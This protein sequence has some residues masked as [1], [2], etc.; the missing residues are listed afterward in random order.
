MFFG[1]TPKLVGYPADW[2]PAKKARNHLKDLT[3]GNIFK[4]YVN[5]L[6]TISLWGSWGREK[7]R[8]LQMGMAVFLLLL[9]TSFLVQIIIFPNINGWSDA[10]PTYHPDPA[11]L[12]ICSIITLCSGW[13]AFGLQIRLQRGLMV[14]DQGVY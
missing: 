1:V 6:L 13:I 10:K 7:S 9:Y 5:E 11:T 8:H 2:Q 4:S 14:S 12:Q 3:L